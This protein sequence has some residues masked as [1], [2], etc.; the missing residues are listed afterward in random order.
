MVGSNRRP[1]KKPPEGGLSIY[2]RKRYAFFGETA[3]SY[4]HIGSRDKGSSIMD[5]GEH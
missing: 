1:T 3:N 2:P 4:H 5:Y